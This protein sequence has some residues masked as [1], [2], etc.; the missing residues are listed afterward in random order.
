MLRDRTQQNQFE[1]QIPRWTAQLEQRVPRRTCQLEAANKELEAFS[2]SV[3]H[4]LR[5]P[6]R[7]IE[8]FID[9]LQIGAGAQLNEECQGFIKTIA[10]SARQMNQLIDDLLAFSRM[11]RTD[12][13]HVG[14]DITA[15]V[16]TA[17]NQ[18]LPGLPDR[19]IVWSI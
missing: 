1:E 5:A 2:Y 16:E 10:S 11:S 13:C 18:L 9:M 14:I 15:L 19:K 7:H 12:I 3:S 17:R 4:D 6:L 8:G